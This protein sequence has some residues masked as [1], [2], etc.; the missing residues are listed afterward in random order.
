MAKVT[1]MQGKSKPTFNPQAS[2]KWEPSDTFEISGQQLAHLY[3]SLTKDVHTT[4]G[5]TPA[6][7]YEAYQVVIEIFKR[8]VEQGAIIEI[9]EVDLGQAKEVESHVHNLFKS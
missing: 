4:E 6:Q 2:Y 7:R 3:H 5:A 8:G 1:S 9:G